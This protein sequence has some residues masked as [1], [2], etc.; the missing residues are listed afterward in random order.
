[1]DS[2]KMNFVEPKLKNSDILKDLDQKLSHLDPIKRH[3][4]KQLIHDYEHLFPD[5]STRTDKIFQDMLNLRVQ[6]L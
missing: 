2:E 3:K 4:L 6:N 5:I 1:M